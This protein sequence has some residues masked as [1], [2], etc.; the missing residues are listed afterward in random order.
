MWCADD[1][2]A[3]L[4]LVKAGERVDAAASTCV[5]PVDWLH[6]NVWATTFAGD[7]SVAGDEDNAEL[8]NRS[9]APP[10]SQPCGGA[11]YVGLLRAPRAS[12]RCRTTSEHPVDVRGD[13]ETTAVGV[14]LGFHQHWGGDSTW[15]TYQRIGYGH[16]W[17]DVDIRFALEGLPTV[18]RALS[19]S[20]DARYHRCG[21]AP[22]S[23]F[24]ERSNDLYAHGALESESGYVQVESGVRYLAT[25]TVELGAELAYARDSDG[26]ASRVQLGAHAGFRV[27]SFADVV[28]RF[29]KAPQR[30]EHALGVFVVFPF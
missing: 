14:A 4:A 28:V 7:F 10:T 13:M 15:A 3:A 23:E 8:F 11:Q 26:R 22:G 6:V 30:D 24:V 21:Y 16:Y 1:P 18:E 17:R 5:H 29:A 12:L 2:Q 27:G 9:G 25:R 19:C 20:E